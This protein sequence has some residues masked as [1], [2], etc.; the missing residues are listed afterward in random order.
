MGL[1]PLKWRAGE[2]SNAS[3]DQFSGPQQLSILNVQR[4]H[5]HSC[6]SYEM[7]IQKAKAWNNME[8]LDAENK[9]SQNVYIA[10]YYRPESS[11][12]QL[13]SNPQCLNSILL[14]APRCSNWQAEEAE[15]MNSSRGDK[16][17]M[18]YR[19]CPSGG[20]A[21]VEEL[22]HSHTYGEWSCWTVTEAQSLCFSALLTVIIHV[23]RYTVRE[24]WSH[25]C[26]CYCRV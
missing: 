12:K 24:A 9:S 8:G 6:C 21:A 17:K 14:E 25:I 3:E 5:T 10:L 18:C 26:P 13:K 4:S 19:A 15:H 11:K 16:S 20:H 23:R 7:N 22:K 2:Q 1:K